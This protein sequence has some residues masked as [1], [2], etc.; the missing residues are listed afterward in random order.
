MLGAPLDRLPRSKRLGLDWI[1]RLLRLVLG[2]VVVSALNVSA[3]AV[4]VE[5]VAA[6]AVAL[7][8]RAWE[9]CILCRCCVCCLLAMVLYR[10]VDAV[11]VF[12]D[13]LGALA[14]SVGAACG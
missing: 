5:N 14:E 8:A 4:A 10:S 3:V 11:A 9:L 6:N 12:A 2:D 7:C 13:T 1:Q